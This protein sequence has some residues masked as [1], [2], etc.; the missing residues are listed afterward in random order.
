[1]GDIGKCLPF[2]HAERGEIKKITL[3]CTAD[4][5]GDFSY[6]IT[7]DTALFVNQYYCSMII[8]IPGNPPPADK[9]NVQIVETQ[10]GGKIVSEEENGKGVLL[11]SGAN[12]FCSQGPGGNCQQLFDC[13]DGGDST[14]EVSISGNSVP[15]AKFRLVFQFNLFL[16]K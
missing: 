6:K 10:Y 4:E 1:M 16:E 5:N 8:G 7:K 13:G 11:Q 2:P 15:F 12:Y 9:T 14:W 3:D